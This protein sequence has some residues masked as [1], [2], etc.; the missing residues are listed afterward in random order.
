MGKSKR[1]ATK[2]FLRGLSKARAESAKA[3]A[4]PDVIRAFGVNLTRQSK[5]LELYSGRKDDAYHIE[6]W[7]SPILRWSIRV[8]IG[9]IYIQPELS[10]SSPMAAI[11]N[12]RGTLQ[13]LHI[14]IEKFLKKKEGTKWLKK[15]Y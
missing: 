14:S 10:S 7:R 1:P 3:P 5:D 12:L 11:R 2:T 15:P 8:R 4:L 9:V 13:N 6:L